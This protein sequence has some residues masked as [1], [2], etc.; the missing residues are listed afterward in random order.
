MA[1]RQQVQEV[2]GRLDGAVIAPTSPGPAEGASTA[3]M[4][5]QRAGE[6]QSVTLVVRYGDAVFSVKASPGEA[7]CARRLQDDSQPWRIESIRGLQGC[8]LVGGVGEVS[9][10]EWTEHG[11]WLHAEWLAT[12]QDRVLAWL[13]EWQ[14]LA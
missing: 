3:E 12:P 5:L 9:F 1:E 2:L 11:N 7:P 4:T 13:N 8:T 10:L 6:D 14:V